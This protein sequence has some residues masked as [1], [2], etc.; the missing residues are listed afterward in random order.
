MYWAG[1]TKK[2]EEFCEMFL[3]PSVLKQDIH[4]VEVRGAMVAHHQAKIK[5]EMEKKGKARE[6]NWRRQQ[7]YIYEGTNQSEIVLNSYSAIKLN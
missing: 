6:H 3:L 2:V 5:E 1:L 4:R 7:T